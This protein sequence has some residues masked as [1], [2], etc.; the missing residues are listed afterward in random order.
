[1]FIKKLILIVLSILS[2]GFTNNLGQNDLLKDPQSIA[3]VQMALEKMYNFEFEEAYKIF[4]PVKE[5]YPKN[6]AS[7][8]FKSLCLTTEYA[9]INSANPVYNEYFSLLQLTLNQSSKILEDNPNDPES[10]FFNLGTHGYLALLYSK[11]NQFLKSMKE[12]LTAY[13]Q[14]KQALKLRDQNPD[15]YFF[16]GL[17]YYYLDQYPE[18]H[19]MVKPLMVFFDEGNRVKGLLELEHAT[20]HGLFTKT[21]AKFFMAFVLMKYENKPLQALQFIQEIALKYPK[22]LNFQAKFIETLIASGKY[23][24]AEVLLQKFVSTK[25][26]YYEV[27]YLIYQGLLNEKH[28]KKHDIAKQMFLKALENISKSGRNTTELESYGYAGLARI[29]LSK[30][31]KKGATSYYNKCL[32]IAEYTSIRNEAKN[33]FKN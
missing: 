28:H 23:E 10:L 3:L 19:P 20:K 30:G 21:E 24:Q 31:N 6:G 22:N 25:S 26:K 1:M 2:V 12:A 8:F 33:Y 11:D 15:F 13:K 7:S 16:S 18:V 5:K 4:E 32:E 27:V 29:E 14:M 17:Y 9:P